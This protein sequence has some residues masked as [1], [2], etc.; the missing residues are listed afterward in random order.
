MRDIS[1]IISKY[2][3]LV[4]CHPERHGGSFEACNIFEY[5]NKRVHN[6]HTNHY[7]VAYYKSVLINL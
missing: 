4:V 2:P 1:W 7:S 3:M 6:P 5:N